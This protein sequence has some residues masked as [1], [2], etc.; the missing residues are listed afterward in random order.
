MLPCLRNQFKK[1]KKT[2]VF[3]YFFEKMG[4]ATSVLLSTIKPS[5]AAFSRNSIPIHTPSSHGWTQSSRIGSCSSLSRN[6]AF[7]VVVSYALHL[8]SSRSGNSLSIL[9]HLPTDIRGSGA[10]GIRSPWNSVTP[11]QVQAPFGI[12]CSDSEVYSNSDQTQTSDA[13]CRCHP[14]MTAYWS[15]RIRPTGDSTQ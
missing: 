12:S 15:G 10:T 4:A 3:L 13:S 5:I 1:T 8:H 14:G 7:V 6:L 2:W 11:V 9:N